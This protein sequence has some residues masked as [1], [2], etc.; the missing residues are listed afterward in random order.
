M[1]APQ[2][3]PAKVTSGIWIAIVLSVIWIL[4]LYGIVASFSFQTLMNRLYHLNQMDLNEIGDFV[5]GFFAPLAVIWLIATVLLQRHDLSEARAEFEKTHLATYQLA[6]FDKRYQVLQ[7]ARLAMGELLMKGDT[8]LQSRHTLSRAI[9][10]ARL[11]F[12]EEIES[13]LKELREQ[14]SRWKRCESQERSY[15][16]LGDKLTDNGKKNLAALNAE[17]EEI[18]NW[19]SETFHNG[20]LDALFRPYLKV[21]RTVPVVALS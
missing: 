16:A 8:S 21:P 12:D 4:I 5:A 14:L 7:D 2:L 17:M 3:L 15:V 10:M 11:L 1:N 13:A 9:E 18:D 20:A 19:L 6:L